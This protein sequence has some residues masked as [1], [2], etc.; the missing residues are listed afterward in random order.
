VE[1]YTT[2]TQAV[3]PGPL[4]C[5]ERA[6]EAGAGVGERARGRQLWW[7]SLR[8]GCCFFVPVAPTMCAYLMCALSG[9]ARRFQFF[10]LPQKA[11]FFGRETWPRALAACGCVWLVAMLGWLPNAA[12]VAVPPSSGEGALQAGR[13]E[14]GS[15][16]S[17]LDLTQSVDDKFRCNAR[18]S[19]AILK[20]PRTGSTW[21]VHAPEHGQSDRLAVPLLGSCASLGPD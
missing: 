21:L 7:A 1:W 6:R 9:V 16:S 15:T 5:V 12:A 10:C 4:V 8:R 17:C 11:A 20:L 18:R 14:Q 3:Q 13:V 19:V 2:G